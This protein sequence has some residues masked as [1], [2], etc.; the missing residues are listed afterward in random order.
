[1]SE[2]KLFADELTA[3]LDDVLF[4]SPSHRANRSNRSARSMQRMTA[5]LAR[6]P[7][8]QQDA[9]LRW[10]GIAAQ[11]NA[12]IAYQLCAASPR[13]FSVFHETG[14]AAEQDADYEAWALAALACYDAEG[15]EPAVRLLG[16][17]ERLQAERRGHSGC[18]FADVEPRLTRF[19]R[20]LEGRSLVLREAANGWTDTETVFLPA[21]I[22]AS[23]SDSQQVFKAMASLLWAQTRYGTFNADLESA[24]AGQANREQALAWLA[25]FEAI[26]LEARIAIELPGLAREIATV[27]GPWP[28]GLEQAV[29][30][31]SAPHA[32][33]NDSLA[34]LSAPDTA[35]LPAPTLVHVGVIDPAAATRVRAARIT[36]DMAVVRQALNTLRGVG[37]AGQQNPDEAL[38]AAAT[39]SMS[40][41]G[42]AASLLPV[43]PPE[44]KAAAESLI[45]DLGSLPPELLSPAGEGRWAPLPDSDVADS[46]G[47][48]DEHTETPDRYY[49]E[50]DYRRSAYRRQWC[51]LYEREGEAGDPDYVAGVRARHAPLI[52]SIRRRFEVLRGEDRMHKHQ[53][54]G[55]EID[56]DALV[57]AHADRRSGAEPAARLFMRRQRSERSLA[58]MF[59]VDMSGST[60]GWINDAERESLVML[61][62]ALETL[63]D[64]YAIYGFSGWTRKRSD[65]YRIKGLR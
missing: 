19:L 1:M 61:C 2:R 5:E 56:I 54:E 52:R 44:A 11:S 32:T 39:Q 7:R 49:D 9:V 46:D 13:A 25:V 12:E 51:H 30:I 21:R 64:R 29:A 57:E 15:L 24:I 27:R 48:P 41:D 43:L 40:L 58:V 38:I 59:M 62:E 31:L 23:A 20:G 33:I 47:T 6:L 35:V 53:L 22:A 45:Q 17:P 65:I 60:K 26:R 16:A 18:R 42:D 3:R 50:W 55:D 37:G 4:A 34:L 36:R 8:R 63:G 14:G 28:P 10:A